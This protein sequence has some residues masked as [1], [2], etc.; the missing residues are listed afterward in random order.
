MRVL[1][2]A[3]LFTIGE[4]SFRLN[5]I[6]TSIPTVVSYRTFVVRVTTF[7]RCSEF[8][9]EVLKWPELIFCTIL[10]SIAIFVRVA[11]VSLLVSNLEKS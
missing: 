10:F 7:V 11:P 2:Q 4:T 9:T 6:G 5:I 3:L 1:R 8:E